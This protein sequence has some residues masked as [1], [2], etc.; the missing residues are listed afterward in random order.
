M[1]CKKAFKVVARRLK[2][3]VTP[4]L[5]SFAGTVVHILEASVLDG[6]IMARDARH[7]AVSAI[8]REALGKGKEISVLAA[9]TLVDMAHEWIN[10]QGQPNDLIVDDPNEPDS[11]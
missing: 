2:E 5:A 3:E 10:K 11:I 4:H 1:G 9:G 8:R 7:I 6:S